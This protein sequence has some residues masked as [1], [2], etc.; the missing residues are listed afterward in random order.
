MIVNG[1]MLSKLPYL[2]TENNGQFS[3]KSYFNINWDKLY[4]SKLSVLY[5]GNKAYIF[6]TFPEI[7]F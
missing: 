3:S 6:C 5:Y 1:Y 2:L 4:S 7:H